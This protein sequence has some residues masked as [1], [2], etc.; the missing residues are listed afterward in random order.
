MRFRQLEA[1]RAVMLCQ[2]VTKAS[3]MLHISQPAVTRL[4]AAPGDAGTDLRA[5]GAGTRT[6]ADRPA[7]RDH[8]ARISRHA[9]HSFSASARRISFGVKQQL[10]IAPS[11]LEKQPSEAH[12][13]SHC[14]CGESQTACISLDAELGVQAVF[15]RGLM[16]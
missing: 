5:V 13:T 6:E 11:A 15:Q 4:P 7:A 3:E 12:W 9:G 14:T 8:V 1:F 2:T 10:R 16:T